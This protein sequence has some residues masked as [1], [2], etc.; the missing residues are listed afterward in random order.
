VRRAS[1]A[2]CSYVNIA[3]R[4]FGVLAAARPGRRAFRS[5]SSKGFVGPRRL[6][7]R[8][9]RG[10]RPCWAAW[11]GMVRVRPRRQCS[12]RPSG[13]TT[14]VVVVV[15]FESSRASEPP[16]TGLDRVGSAT[17]CAGLGDQGNRWASRTSHALCTHPGARPRR[18]PAPTWSSS[19]GLEPPRPAR[20][21]SCGSATRA[22][23]SPARARP[24]AS[25]TSHALGTHLDAPPRA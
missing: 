19:M 3:H 10:T 18:R 12:A 23:L 22:P 8:E 14:W 2:V 7:G 5:G 17:R 20:S 13:C 9:H 6:D 21:R 25:R 4:R 1:G 24:P 16:P 15:A 11:A